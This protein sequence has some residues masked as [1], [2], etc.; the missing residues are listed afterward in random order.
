M[1]RGAWKGVSKR[2]FRSFTLSHLTRDP[3][4][5]RKGPVPTGSFITGMLPVSC[6]PFQQHRQAPPPLSLTRTGFVGR[7]DRVPTRGK[8][9]KK[10]KKKTVN[11]IFSARLHSL[12]RERKRS[13]P[14]L[15]P[16]MEMKSAGVHWPP[17]LSHLSLSPP[18]SPPLSPPPSPMSPI[19]P[20]G[21]SLHTRLIFLPL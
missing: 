19:P 21:N 1:R 20:P 3:H 2:Q 5:G 11:G 7:T 12:P 15:Q 13:L 17:I 9:G 8:K 4:A 6:L 18:P 16:L 10:K 14:G